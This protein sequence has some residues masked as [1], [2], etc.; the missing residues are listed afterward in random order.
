[1]LVGSGRDFR[2]VGQRTGDLHLTVLDDDHGAAD[3]GVELTLQPIRGPQCGESRYVDV[4]LEKDVGLK[5]DNKTGCD[6]VTS[7][8]CVANIRFIFR[9]QSR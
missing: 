1:M 8:V 5:E 4:D 7:I 6:R 3:E 2:G 9:L